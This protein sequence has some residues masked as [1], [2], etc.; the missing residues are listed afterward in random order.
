MNTEGVMLELAVWTEAPQT[1]RARPALSAAARLDLLAELLVAT[2]ALHYEDESEAQA[3]ADIA[4][5]RI[6][7]RDPALKHFWLI[8]ETLRSELESQQSDTGSVFRAARAA[9]RTVDEAAP[10]AS[11]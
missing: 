8:V 10:L 7:R 11:H 5:S 1:A 2:T 3:M 6:L 9:R 4:L